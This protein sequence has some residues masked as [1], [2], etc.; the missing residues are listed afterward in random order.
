MVMEI[1]IAPN[2][3]IGHMLKTAQNTTNLYQ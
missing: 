1:L 2:R 3:G